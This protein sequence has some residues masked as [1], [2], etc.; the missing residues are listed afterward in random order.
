MP[1]RRNIAK[2]QIKAIFLTLFG[3]VA[4]YVKKGGI[5]VNRYLRDN[6]VYVLTLETKPLLEC[7]DKFEK[8]V[9]KNVKYDVYYDGFCMTVDYKKATAVIIIPMYIPRRVCLP[10]S[11]IQR[12]K[13]IKSGT[14]RI[15]FG[16][17]KVIITP[18]P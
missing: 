1:P 6:E 11:A 18:L 8:V 15:T 17:E 9:G 7:F 16:K 14:I 3:E 10:Y 2:I 4:F 13:R 5:S 12:I